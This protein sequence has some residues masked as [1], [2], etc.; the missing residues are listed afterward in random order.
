MTLPRVSPI[1]LSRLSIHVM[2]FARFREHGVL[3][4]LSMPSRTTAARG[5][6]PGPSRARRAG[7]PPDLDPAGRVPLMDKPPE[8]EAEIKEEME[9]LGIDNDATGTPDLFLSGPLLNGIAI[10]AIILLVAG[11]MYLVF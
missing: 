4:I 1:W 3:T 8:T 11:L 9:E 5:P 2:N 10:F 6:V 7:V